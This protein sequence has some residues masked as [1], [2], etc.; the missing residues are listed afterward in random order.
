M[1]ETPTHQIT[2]PLDHIREV[3]AALL[4]EAGYAQYQHDQTWQQ[5]TSFIQHHVD[6]ELH[7]AITNLLKPYADRLRA[8]YDWQIDL[9][10]GLFTLIDVMDTTDK[11]VAHALTPADHHHGL[12]P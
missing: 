4:A 8:T 1:G 10:S 5:I 3:A 9:A 6:P 11:D 2:Y 7:E 12:I